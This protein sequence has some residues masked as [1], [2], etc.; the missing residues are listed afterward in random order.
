MWTIALAVLQSV[1]ES[2]PGV[3]RRPGSLKRVEPPQQNVIG[4]LACALPLASPPEARQLPPLTAPSWKIALRDCKDGGKGGVGS[5]PM[6]AQE[7]IVRS[8]DR[9]ALQLESDATSSWPEHDAPEGGAHEQSVQ[10]RVS[11]APR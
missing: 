6:A 2:V 10:P 5:G 4:L 9:S 7:P 3:G 11:S 1:P 8:V